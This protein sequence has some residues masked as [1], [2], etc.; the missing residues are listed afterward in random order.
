[1]R[2]FCGRSPAGRLPG[3]LQGREAVKRSV[4][5]SHDEIARLAYSYWEN[6]GRHGGSAEE[7]WYRAEREWSEKHGRA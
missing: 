1:M 5:P 3:R 4:K 2:Y 7:D 6:R